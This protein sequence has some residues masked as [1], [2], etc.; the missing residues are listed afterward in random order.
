MTKIPCWGTDLELVQRNV[1]PHH[2]SLI[3]SVRRGARV[4]DGLRG[5]E[6]HPER[7]REAVGDG[8]WDGLRQQPH[9]IR[10]AQKLSDAADISRQKWD[11]CNLQSA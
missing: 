10:W 3:H 6:A 1:M 9:A 8:L 2:P 7:V 4:F 5:L 11:T